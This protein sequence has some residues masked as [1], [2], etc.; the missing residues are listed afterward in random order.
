MNTQKTLEFDYDQPTKESS[1]QVVCLGMIFENNEECHKYFTENLREK[2]QDL[3]FR[4]IEGFPI[5]SSSAPHILNFF[6][7]SIL[8]KYVLF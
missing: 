4:M 7:H 3:E 5:G 6:N 8:W 1:D 2:L